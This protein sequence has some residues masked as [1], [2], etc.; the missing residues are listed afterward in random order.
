MRQTAE[1]RVTLKSVSTS[2]TRCLDREYE[3]LSKLDHPNIVR[4]LER[5]DLE[6]TPYLAMES[7]EAASPLLEHLAGEGSRLSARSA[8]VFAQLV[9]ALDYLHERAMVHAC[10]CPPRIL[11]DVGDEVRLVE[12]HH[13]RRLD[14]DDSEYWPPGTLAGMPYYMSPEHILGGIGPE[15]DYFV[16]GALLVEHVTGR[17]AIQGAVLGLQATVGFDPAQLAFQVEPSQLLPIIR[18]LM[19]P[20]RTDRKASWFALRPLLIEMAAGSPTFS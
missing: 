10:L 12:F 19:Q 1:C 3:I 5:F 8:R 9:D 14:R 17:R 13:T 18:S 6:D 11:V 16:V 4:V 15:S 7:I 2:A 20:A